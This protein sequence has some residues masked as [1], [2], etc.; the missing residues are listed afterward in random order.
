MTK[1]KEPLI[2]LFNAGFRMGSL[3][4][5]MGLTL[6][7]GRYLGLADL[8]TYGLVASCV[9]IGLPLLG[10]RLDYVGMR[11]IVDADELHLTRLLRDQAIFYFLNYLGMALI[12]AFASVTFLQ[13]ISTKILIYTTCLAALES[14]GALCTTNLVALK[15]PVLA[16]FLFFVRA[17]LWVFPVVALGFFDEKYRKAETVLQWWTAGVFLSVIL[18]IYTWRK[19]PWKEAAQTAVDW[20]WIKNGVRRCTLIWVGSVGGTAAANTDRF[21][22]EYFLGREYVGINSFYGSFVNSISAL[23]GSGLFVFTFPQLISKFKQKDLAGFNHIFR[24]MFFQAIVIGGLIC[25]AFGVTVPLLGDLLKRPELLDN[26]HVLWLMLLGTWLKLI[27]ETYYYVLYARHQD[28]AVSYVNLFWLVASL[29][30]NILFVYHFGFIGTGYS[31]VV[32]GLIILATRYY[33]AQKY[34][35]NKYTLSEGGSV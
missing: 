12:V 10:F 7:M 23:M 2:R 6:Y 31:A 28:A 17:A 27:G 18:T 1:Y 19:L 21:V 16:N 5:K 22:V 35:W 34:D 13:E 4:I 8:G 32:S 33:W 9:A 24:K 14:F 15:K 20:P 3:A 29:L 30:T 26:G 11:E 25:V